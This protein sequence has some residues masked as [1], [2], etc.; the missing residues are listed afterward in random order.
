MRYLALDEYFGGIG[1]EFDPFEGVQRAVQSLAGLRQLIVVFHVDNLSSRITGCGGEHD[2]ELF[3]TL[4]EELETPAFE[5]PPLSSI[6]LHG[7]Q[8]WELKASCC[9]IYG[10]RRCPDKE[11]ILLPNPPP[12]YDFFAG[13]DGSD[14]DA[15][16]WAAAWHQGLGM[17]IFHPDDFN[18]NSDSEMDDMSESDGSENIS[19]AA[20]LD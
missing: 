4:P 12:F 2:L 9:P 16:D 14:E 8:H 6:P 1:N 10:W 17:G 15:A 5:I 19:E 11:D 18:P 3:D 20:S 7:F 13:V